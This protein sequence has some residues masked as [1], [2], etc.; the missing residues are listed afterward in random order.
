MRTIRWIIATP[1]NLVLSLISCVFFFLHYA[2]IPGVI[3]YC[4]ILRYATG[5]PTWYYPSYVIE[6]AKEL[7]PNYAVASIGIPLFIAALIYMFVIYKWLELYLGKMFPNNKRY[8]L[9]D[10][11]KIGSVTVKAYHDNQKR[12]ARPIHDS[13]ERNFYDKMMADY[14]ASGNCR[15]NNL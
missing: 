10:G 5:L 3:L 8:I 7:G 1:F 12:A 14:R 6:I 11:L 2:A 4:F 15:D 13:A 9:M